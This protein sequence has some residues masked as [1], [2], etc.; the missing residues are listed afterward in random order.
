MKKPNNI[1]NELNQIRAKLYEETK[2]MSPSEITAYIRRKVAPTHEKYNIQTVSERQ[3][4][5]NV[6]LYTN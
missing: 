2:D 1:E 5:N 3:V 6:Q 4:R